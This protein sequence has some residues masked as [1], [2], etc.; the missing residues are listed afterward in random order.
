M[1]FE[2]VKKA[3]KALLKA[4]NGKSARLFALIQEHPGIFQKELSRLS[5]FSQVE[6]SI[7]LKAL[8]ECKIIA[9]T[10]MG[11]KVYYTANSANVE[12]INALAALINS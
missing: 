10:K 9:Q 3:G 2:K 7:C 8:L 6:T 11:T 4:S 5:G 12:K 1:D